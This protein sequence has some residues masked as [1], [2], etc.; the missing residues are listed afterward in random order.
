MGYAERAYVL[1]YNHF[2]SVFCARIAK[3]RKKKGETSQEHPEATVVAIRC[4]INKIESGGM[5]KLNSLSGFEY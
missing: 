3:K 4:H 2:C 5:S 1:L